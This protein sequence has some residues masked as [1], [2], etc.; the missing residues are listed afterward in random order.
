ML[1]SIPSDHPSIC[2]GI[3]DREEDGF[4][5]LSPADGQIRR[6]VLFVN[7]YGGVEIW[8]KVK[9]GDMP[10]HHL[11]GCIELARMGYEVALAKPLWNFSLRNAIPHDLRLLRWAREWLRPEDILYC[12]HNVLFWIPLLK[13]CRIVRCHIVSL[14][15][16]REPLD[17]AKAH[18]GIIAL[19]PLA[20]QHARKLAPSAK[21]AT[22]SWGAD[23][24]FF[25]KLPYRPD[26]F[27]S[28]GITRRDFVTLAAGASRCNAKLRVICPGIPK[29]ISWPANVDLKDGGRGWNFQ[30]AAISYQALLHDYYGGCAGSL[31]IL[32]KD[33]AGETAVGFTNL[34]EAMAMA[35]PVIVT[36]TGALPS[37]IDVESAGCGLHVPAED[38]RALADAI[39]ELARDPTRAQSMGEAGR[40]LA[41]NHYNIDRYSQ[42]LHAFFESL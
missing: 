7:L 9:R 8:R 30:K 18:S 42:Q 24:R 34:I 25:P 40:R 36:K 19:N 17:F 2:D 16:A 38:P 12:G 6:R 32:R 33:N 23:M 10:P 20:E 39:N 29:E 3:S 28:C 1:P 37:E 26:W 22:L 31:I 27:L 13:Y 35:R 11:W 5:V 21:V 14:L 41:E 15:Y 4:V